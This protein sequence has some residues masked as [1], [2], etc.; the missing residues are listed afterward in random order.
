MAKEETHQQT[1]D[2]TAPPPADWRQEAERR[3]K[4]AFDAAVA[5]ELEPTPPPP[6]W[7]SQNTKGKKKSR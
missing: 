6:W 7:E 2:L 5:P 1:A 3:G 4:N